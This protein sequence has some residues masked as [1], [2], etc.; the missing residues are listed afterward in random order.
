MI[1]W[2]AGKPLTWDITIS[3][4][5]VVSQFVCCHTSPRLHEAG[6]VAELVAA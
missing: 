4:L 5:F 1:P 2:Q 6:I 3:C